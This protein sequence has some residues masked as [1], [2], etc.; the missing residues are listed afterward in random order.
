M[1]GPHSALV[2]TSEGTGGSRR[3]IQIRSFEHTI[4]IEEL[5]GRVKQHMTGDLSA[6][7]VDLVRLF[8]AGVKRRADG[9]EHQALGMFDDDEDA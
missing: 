2:T 4:S 3:Y 1:I 5:E 9:K 7:E 6:E 8:H